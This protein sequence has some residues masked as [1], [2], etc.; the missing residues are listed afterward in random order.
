MGKPPEGNW[1]PDWSPDP[2]SI[3]REHGLSPS[4]SWGDGARLR[5]GADV[6]SD[7]SDFTFTVFLSCL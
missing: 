6:K 2:M 7:V 3:G 5:T 4:V 1:A